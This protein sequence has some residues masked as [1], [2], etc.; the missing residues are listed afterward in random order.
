MTFSVD[1]EKGLLILEEKVQQEQISEIFFSTINPKFIIIYNIFA[2]N[3]KAIIEN[4]KQLER[5]S[6]HFLID[7]G[8]NIVQFAKPN[9]KTYLKEVLWI[10]ELAMDVNIHAIIIGVVTLGSLEDRSPLE[11][12]N[13][14]RD[15]DADTATIT[16]CDDFTYEQ[17]NSIKKLLKEIK[18]Q[19]PI[20]KVFRSRRCFFRGSIG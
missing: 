20:E 17:S 11:V 19:Y 12:M 5:E 7:K 9:Q 6:L 10:K 2:E 1:K 13:Y 4:I 15:L 3:L 18:R 8:G 14:K 16:E